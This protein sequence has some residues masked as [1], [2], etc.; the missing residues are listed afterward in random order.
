MRS[1]HEANAIKTYREDVLSAT[2]KAPHEA[3]AMK[4]YREKNDVLSA[5]VV[6]AFWTDLYVF[7]EQNFSKS[8]YVVYKIKYPKFTKPYLPDNCIPEPK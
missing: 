2:V 3:N 1:P 6:R 5:T 4:T 7:I 8:S